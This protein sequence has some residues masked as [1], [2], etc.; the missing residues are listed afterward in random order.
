MVLRTFALQKCI[1]VSVQWLQKCIFATI[2]PLALPLF[3]ALQKTQQHQCF[4]FC[5][6]KCIT[7]ICRRLMFTK[8]TFFV[9]ILFQKMFKLTKIQIMQMRKIVLDFVFE[10]FYSV[11]MQEIKT[12]YSG[13]AT[14]VQKTIAAGYT[15]KP[16]VFLIKKVKC[17]TCFF[18]FHFVQQDVNVSGQELNLNILQSQM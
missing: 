10:H 14:I 6:T 7:K 18:N 12:N 5:Y 1:F 13:Y 16:L 8:N 9:H 3:F 11:K 17:Q 4:T 15:F 2:M